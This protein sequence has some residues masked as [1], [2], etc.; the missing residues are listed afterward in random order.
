MGHILCYYAPVFGPVEPYG[1]YQRR[2]CFMCNP[3]LGCAIP[4]FCDG[5]PIRALCLVCVSHSVCMCWCVCVRGFVCVCGC[6]CVALWSRMVST[7][8]VS[9][10]CATTYSAAPSRACAT[11]TPFE[12]CV[13]CVFFLSLL[14]PVSL[15]VCVQTSMFVCVSG[16]LGVQFAG[17]KAYI[18]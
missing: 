9:A 7:R 1:L 15:C 12:P 6:P 13:W 8:G 5:D 11:V 4:G 17:K 16:W 10:S 2:Q 3:I 14:L 18:Q